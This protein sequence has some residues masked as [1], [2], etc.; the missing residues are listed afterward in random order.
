MLIKFKLGW[1]GGISFTD[2]G[3][4]VIQKKKPFFT[5]FA[6]LQDFVF[7]TLMKASFQRS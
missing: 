4:G 6:R 2:P 7:I 5:R 3:Q 1:G